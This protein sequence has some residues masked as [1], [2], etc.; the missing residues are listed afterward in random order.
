MSD[1]KEINLDEEN[2]AEVCE[3]L[4]CSV[5]GRAFISFAADV[6]TH[7]E[8]YTVPQYGDAGEDQVT[9]YTVEEC[10]KQ[11]LKYISRYGRNSR[12]GQQELDFMK[13]AHYIQLAAEKHK[14]R[15]NDGGIISS[16]Y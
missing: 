10:L 12:E 2:I 15:I 5:R 8:Q 7:I 1:V 16:S 13:A 6:L 4:G 9:E 11:A 14:E 3:S